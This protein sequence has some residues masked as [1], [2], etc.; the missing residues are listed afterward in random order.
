MFSMRLRTAGAL[1]LLALGFGCSQ[2]K[3]LEFTG[4]RNFNIQ[5]VSF[6]NSKIGLEIGVFNPNKFDIR[7]D[8]VEADISLSGTHVGKYR[9]DSGFMIP[10]N[11][12]FSMPVELNVKNSALVG[13]ALG[14]LSGDSIPYSLSGKVRAGRKIATAEI[15]F[16][17]SGRLTQNDFNSS[18]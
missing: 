14:I 2:P 5:P 4:F 17:Y 11:A 13:N 1:L 16:T 6:L 9:L 3:G 7:V 18:R 15:P 8:K 10:A 12:S